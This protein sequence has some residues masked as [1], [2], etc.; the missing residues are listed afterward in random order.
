MLTTEA[1]FQISNGG[2]VYLRFLVPYFLALSNA[3]HVEDE[4]LT[5][6]DVRI[7]ARRLNIVLNV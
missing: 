1:T 5:D 3:V 4:E 7:A 6:F 2:W